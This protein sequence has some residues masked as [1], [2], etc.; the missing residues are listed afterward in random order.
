M[1]PEAKKLEEFTLNH[2]E[3]RDTGR[4][5]WRKF[6]PYNP[7]TSENNTAGGT[8]NLKVESLDDLFEELPKEEE[9]PAPVLPQEEVNEEA[10]MQDKKTE[11]KEDNSIDIQQELEAKFDEL[12]GPIEQ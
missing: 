6:N 10:K 5:E 9:T 8:Q 4:G 7:Y 12:F 1:K 11:I 3:P 2:N